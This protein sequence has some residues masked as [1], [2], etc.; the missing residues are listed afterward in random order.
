MPF[1]KRLD[2]FFCKQSRGLCQCANKNGLPQWETRFKVLYKLKDWRSQSLLILVYRILQSF[3][4]FEFSLFASRDFDSCA[5]TRIAA[6]SSCTFRNGKST[7][8]NQTNFI[9][10]L[11]SVGDGSNKCI[12]S[13]S[14]IS[15]GKACFA[16]DASN[17]FVFIRGEDSL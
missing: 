11:Q 6:G 13:L 7:K 3:T 15:F 2:N 1:I 16:S 8:T 17:Q 5:G 10:F 4:G 14:R 12:K 9:T